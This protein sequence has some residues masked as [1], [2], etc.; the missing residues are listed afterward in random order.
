MQAQDFGFCSGPRINAFG[1]M[2]NMHHFECLL[3]EET[4]YGAALSARA[5]TA[6]PLRRHVE[7]EMRA[8]WAASR[9]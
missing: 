9:S 3:T 1:R 8:Q 5:E 6:K 2:D 4:G 7:G